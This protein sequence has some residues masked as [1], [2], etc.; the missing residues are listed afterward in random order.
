MN[1]RQA[2]VCTIRVVVHG[3]QIMV[4]FGKVP[5]LNFFKLSLKIYTFLWFVYLKF[6]ANHL[7]AV[8]VIRIIN[9]RCRSFS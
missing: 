5:G 9:K 2:N 4:S 1:Y 6:Y 7:F 3:T 8:H